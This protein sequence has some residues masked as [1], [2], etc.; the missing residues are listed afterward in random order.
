[1]IFQTTSYK[2]MEI[3]YRSITT[4]VVINNYILFRNL[5]GLVFH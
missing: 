3:M 4:T 2:T 1:M 5:E